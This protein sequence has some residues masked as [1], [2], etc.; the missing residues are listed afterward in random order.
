MKHIVA[1]AT[2]VSLAI[3]PSAASAKPKF[4]VQPVQIGNE[5]VRYEQGVATVE[6]FNKEGSVQIQP[7]PI[8]HG[9]LVFWVGVYNAGRQASHIDITNFSVQ[10]GGQPLAVFSRT[11]LEKKAKNRAMWTQIGLAALGGLAAAGAA[12]QRDHYRSTLY[13]P[14]GTYRAYYSAPSTAGQIQAAAITAGT[15]YAIYSVQQQLDATRRDLADTVVQLST[16]DPNDSYGGKIVLAKIKDK[17]LPKDV[18][19]MLDWN[20]EKYPFA[21]RL[22]KPG[23]PAP[24]F[25]N[26]LPEL[27]EPLDSDLPVTE[28]AAPVDAGDSVPVAVV[29]ASDKVS[30]DPGPA[31]VVTPEPGASVEP[32]LTSD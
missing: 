5:T 30:N 26:K 27:P 12:S 28:S 19:I 6:L 23:T 16:V 4:E 1:A 9:S 2:A 31:P 21:F 18:T 32:A 13:T 29:P 3:A 11:E 10:A 8:D 20:G 17:K 15:G 22:A 25:T 7:M 24:A 14:R